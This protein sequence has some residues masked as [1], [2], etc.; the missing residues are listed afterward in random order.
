MVGSDPAL[1]AGGTDYS[2]FH[3]QLNTAAV[4][5]WSELAPI[6]PTSGFDLN[7][8]DDPVNGPFIG[9]TSG[10]PFGTL[11]INLSG[12]A[13]DT[14]LFATPAGRHAGRRRDRRERRGRRQRRR[15]VR[16]RGPL[17]RRARPGRVSDA[18][19]PRAALRHAGRDRLAGRSGPG[20]PAS[21]PVHRVVG[22]ERGGLLIRGYPN[23]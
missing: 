8:P 6:N 13:P 11:T 15:L 16:P 12:I 5:G 2:R 1:T 17:N 22:R 3:L 14:A 18:G 7:A 21:Y 23:D 10:I 9:P 4:P 19:H 20:V